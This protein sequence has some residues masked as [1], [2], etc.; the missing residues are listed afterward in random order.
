MHT[1]EDFL[2]FRFCIFLRQFWILNNLAY[3]LRQEAGKGYENDA[4]SVWRTCM[5]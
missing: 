4:K 1:P 3:T 2:E 5:S